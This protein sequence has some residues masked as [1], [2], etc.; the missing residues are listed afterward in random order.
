MLTF[1]LIFVIALAVTLA[2]IPWLR[3]YALNAGFVDTP[4]ARKVHVTPVPLLGGVAIF[5]GAIL[6]VFFAFRGAVPR[7]IIG[8]LIAGA[9]VALLGLVDD[10]R[11]L[12]PVMRLLVQLAAAA[13]LVA[14]GVR[15]RLP[16]PEF[17]NI[18]LT[19]IWILGITNAINL[20]DN[21]DGLSA[22]VAAVA[23]AFMM[24]LG[25]FNGQY[26][27]SALAAAILGACAGFLRY[28]F[29][30]AQIFMGDAGAYF[31]GFWLAVL[32]IQLRFPGN[33]NFVTWMVP[34]F[35]LALPIF[36]TTLVTI[37]RLRRGVHPFTGGKD[38]LSHRL[39]ARG[40][41]PREAVLLLYL[42]AGA[43][44]MI[45]L[46]ITEASVAEGYLVGGVVAVVAAYAI[47][48]LES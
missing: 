32:G 37:S 18:A 10:R 17:L 2:S 11:G 40:F 4:N 38:H 39:V 23:A 12:P 34:L 5:A 6:A 44:G 45:A 43:G 7:T 15:V 3:R 14:F 48:K 29:N 30:P 41:T 26:L 42:I 20:L 9:L 13:I 25:A 35:V 16:I 28:N 36:D 21:M 22:G 24:L 19:I 46:F 47:W 27:V 8:A 1:I 33:V 31:L